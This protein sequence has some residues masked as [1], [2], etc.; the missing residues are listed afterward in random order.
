MAGIWPHSLL[1][2]HDAEGVPLA[3]ALAYFFEAGTSTPLTTYA[4]YGLTSERTHPV[5]AD[6]LGRFPAVYLD[7][8]T[9]RC[10]LTD[11]DGVQIFDEDGI[12]V[13]GASSGG[14]GGGTVFDATALLDTGDVIW[15]YTTGAR[16]GFVRANGRTIG[17]ASSGASERA[18]ADTQALYE[19]LWGVDANLSVAGGRGA[20][21]AA[22]F[23]A[24]KALTLPDIK[25][26][27][28]FGLDDMG[29]TEAERITTNG[30]ILGAVGGTETHT[31]ASSEMPSHTHTGT[32]ASGGSHTHTVSISSGGAHTHDLDLVNRDV[33]S[34]S[35]E[36]AYSYSGSG[37]TDT[38]TTDSDGTHTHTATAT[39]GGDHTHTFTTAAAGSGG[40]HANMP[41]YILGTFYIRL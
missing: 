26:R 13:V 23:A 7:D 18:N 4:D 12:P 2:Q 30:T 40:A 27:A 20:S 17:S 25:G 10:R 41:P 16:S 11:S 14:G 9:Y 39:S 38:V 28:L 37:G 19:H 15:S 29:A 31:L 33:A 21:A 24:N 36:D 6:G 3:G 5:E 32:T 34:G 35:G 22:D 1:Q 8:G